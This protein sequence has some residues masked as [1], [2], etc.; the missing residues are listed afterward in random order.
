MVAWLEGQSLTTAT[1]YL[2]DIVAGKPLRGNFITKI[3]KTSDRKKHKLT[4]RHS[5]RGVASFHM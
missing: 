2:P 5:V 4:S 1:E 3:Q